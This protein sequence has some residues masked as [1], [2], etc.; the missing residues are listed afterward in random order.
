LLDI[1]ELF[2]ISRFVFC[3][4]CFD[5]NT[6]ITHFAT[7][8]P[9]VLYT[10]YTILFTSAVIGKSANTKVLLTGLIDAS[11]SLRVILFISFALI[12]HRTDIVGLV[13]NDPSSGSKKLITSVP[14]TVESHQVFVGDPVLVRALVRLFRMFFQLFLTKRAFFVISSSIVPT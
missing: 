8:F 12:V 3:I 11:W 5:P 6:V 1:G 2:D 14:D 10:L 4:A 7:S 9:S 13:D